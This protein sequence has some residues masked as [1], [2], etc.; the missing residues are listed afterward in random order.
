MSHCTSFKMEFADKRVLFKAMRNLNLRPENR[1][2]A[3]YSSKFKKE[4]KIDGNIIGKLLTGSYEKINIFFIESDNGLIPNFESSELS[5]DNLQHK[6]KQLLL[7]IK[8]EYIICAISNFGN[9]LRQSGISIYTEV[10]NYN[11]TT[12][13]TISIG[14]SDKK[15]K[16]SLNSDGEIEE[17]IQ[18]ITGD[19]CLNVS[20]ILESQLSTSEHLSRI[21][22]PEYNITVEDRVLHVFRVRS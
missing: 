4:L 17:V 10:E 14:G 19:V 13:Y 1:V 22:T 9:K 11:D 16:L 8:Q 5:H 21:L 3:E 2:W 7:K 15:L 6:S 12:S 20:K 18:G